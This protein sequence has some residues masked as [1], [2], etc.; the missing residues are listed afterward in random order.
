M[1]QGYQ[2]QGSH[3]CASVVG[4]RNSSCSPILF[5]YSLS[6]F[7]ALSLIFWERYIVFRAQE[8]NFDVIPYVCTLFPQL[9]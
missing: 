6:E 2:L 4:G 8:I 7:Y 1:R 3:K 5:D 9:E